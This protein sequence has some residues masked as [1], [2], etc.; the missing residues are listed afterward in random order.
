M[1]EH[2][3]FLVVVGPAKLHDA[4]FAGFPP[5]GQRELLAA[6]GAWV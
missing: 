1:D 6:D 2:H 3:G 5:A 4:G